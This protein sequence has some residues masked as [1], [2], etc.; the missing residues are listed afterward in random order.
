METL[1][2]QIYILRLIFITAMRGPGG[3]SRPTDPTS[4]WPCKHGEISVPLA[5][6]CRVPREHMHHRY[7]RPSATAAPPPRSRPAAHPSP[8]PAAPLPCPEPAAATRAAAA[9][10]TH[11]HSH[12]H[13]LHAHNTHDHIHNTLL[14]HHD[15]GAVMKQ[16]GCGG[17]LQARNATAPPHLARGGSQATLRLP[18][19]RA[20][21]HGYARGVRGGVAAA[22]AAP[23]AAPLLLPRRP[24]AAQDQCS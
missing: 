3:L 1:T 5:A 19:A 23:H 13:T 2:N 9:S 6:R 8:T 18:S 10:Y 12:T 21:T 7:F 24:R 22:S 20:H 11:M 17:A 14:L 4:I 16:Q 15:L